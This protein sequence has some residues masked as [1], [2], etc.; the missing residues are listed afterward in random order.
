MEELGRNAFLINSRIGNKMCNFV[1]KNQKYD[2]S[3]L[4]L[5]MVSG[6]AEKAEGG[7]LRNMNKIG[8]CS[9]NTEHATKTHRKSAGIALP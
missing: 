7:P 4:F 8:N 1:C 6:K 9:R 5:I 3:M 2:T